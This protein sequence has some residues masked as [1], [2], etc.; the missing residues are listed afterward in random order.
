[1]ICLNQYAKFIDLFGK[2]YRLKELEP[3]YGI[4]YQ[5]FK[6]ILVVSSRDFVLITKR[7]IFKDKQVVVGNMKMRNLINFLAK[8]IE[9]SEAPVKKD[10]VRGEL[11]LAGWIL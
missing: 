2:G 3:G 5:K 10:V 9:Y 4:I 7:F 6:R 11:I 8:S 1:M